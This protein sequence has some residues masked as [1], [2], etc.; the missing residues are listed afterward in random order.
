MD[1]KGY[2]IKSI[3]NVIK[4]LE[5]FSLVDKNLRLTE[6]S[7]KLNINKT[8][9]FRI[10]IN[11]EEE[12]FLFKNNDTKKYELGFKIFELGHIV[13]EEML[14]R[15]IS[16]PIMKEVNSVTE[17]TVGLSIVIGEKKANIEKVESLHVIK[18]TITLGKMYPLYAGADGRIFLA[19][20][21]KDKIKEIIWK[22]K[23]IAF[24]DKTIIDP[25]KLEHNLSEVKKK[26]YAISNGELYN[27]LTAIAVPIFRNNKEVVSVLYVSG[28]SGRFDDEK[29]SKIIKLLKDSANKISKKL[30]YQQ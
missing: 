26:G 19:F 24:T 9:L 7:K 22:D 13:R 27:D 2:K 3:K 15:S 23:L 20:S 8:T 21:S 16:Y 1:K 17:E 5:A 4:V 25:A 6:L 11:L 28:P 10:L 18:H 29:I 14:L 12:G 30:G